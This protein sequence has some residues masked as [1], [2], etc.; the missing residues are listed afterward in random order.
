MHSELRSS[1]SQERAAWRL[2]SPV[3]PTSP[4]VFGKEPQGSQDSIRESGNNPRRAQNCNCQE[5]PVCLLGLNTIIICK[6]FKIQTVQECRV[7]VRVGG[8]DEGGYPG[9]EESAQC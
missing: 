5:V 9:P 1:S 4:E 2:L 6:H 3:S 7:G 8:G